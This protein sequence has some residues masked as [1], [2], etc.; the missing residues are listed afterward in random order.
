MCAAHVVA[1]LVL[2]DAGAAAGAGLGVDRQ[3]AAGLRLAG[4]LLLPALHVGAAHGGVPLPAAAG[5]P[6]AA[7][8]A[9]AHRQPVQQRPQAQHPGAVRGGAAAH[10]LADADVPAHRQLPVQLLLARRPPQRLGQHHRA[11]V[12]HAGHGARA[13]PLLLAAGDAEVLPPA[14]SAEAVAARL[15]AQQLLLLAA[16]HRTLAAAA[17]H[18]GHDGSAA[19]RR[20]RVQPRLAHPLLAPAVQVQQDQGDLGRLPQQLAERA[21]ALLHGGPYVF[22]T[23]QANGVLFFGRAVALVTAV[24]VLI[25]VI[26][27]DI[28]CGESLAR[29]QKKNTNKQRIVCRPVVL[30]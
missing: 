28:L 23:N 16:A 27:H 10:A 29:K 12:L 11:A 9:A 22:F 3:P 30:S 14:R 13:V 1:A 26:R 15:D 2:L 18:L 7:A 25:V 20:R 6:G 4:A 21:R 19:A 24:V 17:P 8:A 5:A